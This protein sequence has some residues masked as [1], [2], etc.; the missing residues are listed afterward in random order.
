MYYFISVFIVIV[1]ARILT[2]SWRKVIVLPWIIVTTPMLL[3]AG[4]ANLDLIPSIISP[5][6]LKT[7]QI[8][9]A[10]TLALALGSFT[11]RNIRGTMV[12]GAKDVIW[13]EYTLVRV[14][15]FVTFVAFCANMLEFLIAGQIPLF[16]ADPDHARLIA[17]KNGFIHVFSVLSGHLVPIASLIL[18]T[19]KDLKKNTRRILVAIII[20]NFTVL[21]LWIAR[22]MLIYPIVTAVAMNYLLNQSTFTLKKTV[23]ILAVFILIISGVKYVRDVTRFGP[24]MGGPR[25]R[26]VSSFARTIIESSSILYLTI[27]LNYEILNR[28]A[29]TIP[30]LAPHSHGRIIGSNLIAYIP[31]TGRPYSELEL[32]NKVL[33]K[34]EHDLGLTSTLFGIP[35]L[36]FG[37]PGVLIISFF[38]GL[39]YKS[40]WHRMFEK[41][42]PESIFFYG[43]LISM[44]IFIPYVFMYSQVNFTWFLLTSFPI[45]FLCSCRVTGTSFFHRKSRIEFL[46]SRTD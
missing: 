23:T 43:Y 12:V 19:G 13:D 38:V 16:A 9:I 33:K 30:A 41:G 25:N 42:T 18:L 34:N 27:T 36:D 17:S 46:Q 3:G 40:V 39:L 24:D 20:I 44:T 37:L 8:V 15:I 2:G 11:M 32:Q 29:A 1:F 35:F 26:N 5:W 31:G 28:Y 10:G 4:L 6:S 14:L 21:I 22:G 7:H 45:I